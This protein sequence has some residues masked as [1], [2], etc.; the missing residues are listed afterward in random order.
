MPQRSDHDRDR[1]PGSLTRR[2][3]VVTAAAG[4]ALTSSVAVP[5]AARAMPAPTGAAPPDPQT[6]IRLLN[7]SLDA[8]QR[9]AAVFPFD[10]PR[11]TVVAADWR[12]SEARIDRLFDAGQQRLIRRLFLALHGPGY[13]A[14]ALDQVERDNPEAGLNGCAVALFEPKA[15]DR[16]EFVLSG[17]HVTCR[18]GGAPDSMGGP[19]FY[20]DGAPPG[21]GVYARQWRCGAELFEAIGSDAAARARSASAPSGVGRVRLGASGVEAVHRA[22]EVMVE[23]LAGGAPTVAL[24]RRAARHD[25]HLHLRFFRDMDVGNSGRTDSW[26]VE[27]PGLDWYFRGRPH[28]HTWLRLA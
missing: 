14:G 26:H 21:R 5:L 8:T 22:L 6:M 2:E 25:G 28:L 3:F 16:L 10:D 13:E 11:R 1:M 24:R 7:G 23:P 4:V 12:I 27:G 15:G 20:G 9:S 19:V 17:R 18:G